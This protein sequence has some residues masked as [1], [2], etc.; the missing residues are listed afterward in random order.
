MAFFFKKAKYSNELT[1]MI[2][3]NKD[4]TVIDILIHKDLPVSIRNDVQEI[5][6][7]FFGSNGKH[8]EKFEELVNYAL[9]DP[10]Y[11]DNY[12]YC[13][14]A[15]NILSSVAKGFQTA[16]IT[17]DKYLK[18]QLIRFTTSDVK[19]DPVFSGHF[20]RIVESVIRFTQGNFLDY[21]LKYS[22]TSLHHFLIKNIQI[23]SYQQALVH[24]IGEC[25]D[26]MSSEG[27][28]GLFIELAKNAKNNLISIK[29]IE[30]IERKYI[31]NAT[32]AEGTEPKA[33]SQAQEENVTDSNQNVVIKPKHH[34]KKHTSKKAYDRKRSSFMSISAIELVL[35]ESCQ[36][37]KSATN[38]DFLKILIETGLLA[39]KK[40]LSSTLCLRLARKIMKD[41]KDNLYAS[42]RPM[43]S[44]ELINYIINE[45]MNDI[46]F[47]LEISDFFFDDVI[48]YTL[49]YFFNTPLNNNE[50]IIYNEYFNSIVVHQ[51][52]MMDEENLLNF[53]NKFEKKIKEGLDNIMNHSYQIDFKEP[54]DRTIELTDA[55]KNDKIQLI[56]GYVREF[57]RYLDRKYTNEQTP[58]PKIM[59][60]YWN[61]VKKYFITDYDHAIDE[62]NK[63]EGLETNE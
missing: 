48:P 51:V 46:G 54:S 13:R 49:E 36:H 28:T 11:K 56:N 5:T 10:N 30:T 47:M 1:Q 59:N 40:S 25:A 45:N 6:D 53:C 15:A 61:D 12:R 7:Y 17:N 29:Q 41:S 33:E 60:D 42:V 4:C 62:L 31:K 18:K 24:L 38:A 44:Q 23:M 35:E 16:Y 43:F 52:K 55:P 37:T 32:N 34:R 39:K 63:F 50:Q 9:F 3:S 27:A 21:F 57:V 2:T 20:Q 14:N 26:K 19:D 22:K 8:N 58:K